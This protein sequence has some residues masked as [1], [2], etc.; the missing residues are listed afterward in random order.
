VLNASHLICNLYKSTLIIS[1]RDLYDYLTS[2][3]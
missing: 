3:K 2:L 1:Q